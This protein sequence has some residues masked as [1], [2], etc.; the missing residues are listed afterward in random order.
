MKIVGVSADA[1][2]TLSVV[3]IGGFG[4]TLVVPA[5]Q[6]TVEMLFARLANYAPNSGGRRGFGG[7]VLIGL[8]LGLL[9]TPCVGPILA[10]VITL[11]IL[12]Q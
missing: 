7:G 12:G 6:K 9:W 5:V 3:V 1:L 2:R 10:S 8:S 4:I 11:A